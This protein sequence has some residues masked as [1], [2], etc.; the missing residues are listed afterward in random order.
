MSSPIEE[1]AERDLARMQAARDANAKAKPGRTAKAA[2][3]PRARFLCTASE[4][5]GRPGVYWIGVAQDRSTGETIE[6]EPQWI[7]SPVEIA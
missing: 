1:R 5:M 7:C 4:A 6:G 2:E 3:T